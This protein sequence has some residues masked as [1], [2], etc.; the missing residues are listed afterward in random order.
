MELKPKQKVYANITCDAY[1]KPYKLIV[2]HGNDTSE[3]PIH[4]SSLKLVKKTAR[5]LFGAT[6]I[7]I[8]MT[9]G[10]D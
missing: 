3:I 6:D 9:Q 5:E 10:K 4:N 2:V 8:S 7:Y 1:G